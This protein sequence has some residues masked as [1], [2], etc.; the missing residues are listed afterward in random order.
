MELKLYTVKDNVSDEFAPPFA[1]KN[2]PVAIRQFKGLIKNLN[3]EDYD[4]Y[5][6]GKYDTDTGIIEM[7]LPEKL[8]FGE[9]K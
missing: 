2:D 9:V 7:C 3:P 5:F 4:I 8:L 1:A 6:L